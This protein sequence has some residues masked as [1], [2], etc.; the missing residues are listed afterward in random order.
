MGFFFSILKYFGV[1][2]T[3]RETIAAAY[4]YPN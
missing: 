1:A 2:D 3:S 4:F